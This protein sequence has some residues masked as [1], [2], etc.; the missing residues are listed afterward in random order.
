MKCIIGLG[1]IGKEYE[2]TRHNMGFVM[3]DKLAEKNN[4]KIDKKMKKYIYGEGNING[5]KVCL[6]KPTTY[7]NLSGEAIVELMNWYKI[8]KEDIVVIYDDIDIPFGD[9]R[10]R[11]NGSAGT[12]NGMRNIIAMIKTEDFARIRVGI[13]NR[14]GVPIPLVD[15]VLQRMSK[16]EIR[17]ID[18]AIYNIVEENA[19]KFL[20][21]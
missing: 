10:Y 21:K 16:Y 6:V 17:K 4:I 9:V 11:L 5:E 18:D 12:H 13:E 3:L 20:T 7:M 19:N 1:N 14:N 15:Y 8:D 2:Y